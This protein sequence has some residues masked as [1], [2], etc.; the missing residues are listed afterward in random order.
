MEDKDSIPREPVGTGGRPPSKRLAGEKSPYLL[1]HAGNP[2]DWYPWGEEAFEQAK[3]EDKPVFLSIGYS[4]CH[5]CH[6]MEEESFADG[7]VAALLNEHF[8]SVKVDREERPDI[9]HIYM[10][11][12]QAMTGSGGWPLTII[13]TP[14]KK[15]FFAGTYIPKQNH[16]GRMGLVDL[17]PHIAEVWREDREELLKA[18]ERAGEFL[19]RM[20]TGIGKAELSDD[21]FTG[22][23][24]WF[25][26]SFDERHGGF[27]SAPKFP[28]PHQLSLLLRLWRRTGDAVALEMATKTLT[29]MHRGG[30]FDQLG[31]GF[32]RYSTDA[33]W[34][35]PHFEK[36][37]YDQAMLA[38]AFLEAYQALGAGNDREA[39][40]TA[41][42]QIF[43]Y[44]LF[45]MTSPEGG[46]YSSEDA[47]SEGQEGRYY[48]WN[49]AQI[50]EVLGEETAG[51]ITRF[52]G[53]TEHGHIE[54]GSVLN[55]GGE[56]DRFA[57][58]EGLS[59]EEFAAHFEEARQR[60]LT[61]RTARTRPAR[62][63]KILTDWNG[64]M[65]AALARGAQ[66][67][68]EPAYRQA[69]SDAAAFNLRK[70]RRSDGR[71]LHRYRDGEAAIPA[72]IDDYAF[73]AWGLIE[74]YQ[75][76]FEPVHL[77]EALRLTEDMITLFWDGER[78]GFY[79]TGSDAEEVLARPTDIYDGAIPS[80]NSVAALN[81]LRLGRI[82]MR[83]DLEEKAQMLMRRFAST[84]ENAPTAFSQFLVALDFALGPSREIVIVG[85]PEADDTV[86]LLG[87]VRERFM[88]D[89]VVIVTGEGERSEEMTALMPALELM[90]IVNGRTTVYLCENFSCN[91]P[92]NTVEELATLLDGRK[93]KE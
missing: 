23:L 64:L 19:Q 44:V 55:I 56:I 58:D 62:D 7:E 20:S 25:R 50:R 82:T 18:G 34:L 6:V 67:L 70:M 41:A 22:A 66:V 37:L 26:R 24:D 1:Q 2:V 49:P 78:G 74:L 47:D 45:E 59:R 36:M 65:I 68:D 83:R 90:R 80:G 87:T 32:H 27:G 54:G 52:F 14:E 11:V 42:R 60:L 8:V 88:P 53:V 71:L 17:L 31:F 30:I 91:F 35:V 48:L 12:C 9:D 5:W 79:L 76:T 61:A 15:P 10:A 77:R 51:R 92:V 93:K 38:I 16:F 21:L 84:V 81:L 72:F 40:A 85:D 13:M 28:S 57:A 33:R 3:A 63:D 86:R 29:A 4:A 75:T 89:T 73:L 46:F 69:A 39:M 43:S